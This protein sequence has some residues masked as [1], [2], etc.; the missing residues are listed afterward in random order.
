MKFLKMLNNTDISNVK[1][2]LAFDT[3]EYK[4][5][6]VYLFAIGNILI[7]FLCVGGLVASP[8]TWCVAIAESIA[9]I[10]FMIYFKIKVTPTKKQ[11]FLYLAIDWLFMSVNI[12]Y[13]SCISFLQTDVNIFIPLSICITLA[14]LCS[15][16]AVKAA[17]KKIC[18]G[19]HK[20]KKLATAIISS[21]ATFGAGLGLTLSRF[22][23]KLDMN[24]EI[25]L[26]AISGFL[27]IIFCMIS[28][29]IFFRWYCCYI[30]EKAENKQAKSS[31]FNE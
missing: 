25:Y 13:L 10:A 16:L 1:A 19:F 2:F 22:I 15:Y 27:S 11:I 28:A 26:G 18:D 17:C 31:V 4:P 30:V 14:F 12:C 7:P 8:I 21:V 20:G 23:E 24:E 29:C 5:R 3:T 6:I 9:L